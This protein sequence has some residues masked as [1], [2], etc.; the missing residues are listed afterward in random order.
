MARGKTKKP[1]C[2]SCAS[3]KDA[4]CPGKT[5]TCKDY[6]FRGNRHKGDNKKPEIPAPVGISTEIK[7]KEEGCKYY[8]VKLKTGCTRGDD[9]DNCGHYEFLPTEL[10]SPGKHSEKNLSGIPNMKLEKKKDEK[11]LS[12]SISRDATLSDLVQILQ[13]LLKDTGIEIVLRP[14]K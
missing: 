10:R 11:Q 3:Y 7:C 8:D 6:K 12:Y 13:L 2:K 4:T 1:S 14:L 9:P 5:E